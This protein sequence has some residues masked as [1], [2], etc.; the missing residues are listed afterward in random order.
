MTRGVIKSA[1]VLVEQGEIRKT[2]ICKTLHISPNN[3]EEVEPDS[4][5]WSEKSSTI[6]WSDHLVNPGVLNESGVIPM[7]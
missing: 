6:Q 1:E 5:L 2:L 7:M 4:K 3:D